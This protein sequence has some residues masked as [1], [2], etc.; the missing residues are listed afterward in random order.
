MH[1]AKSRRQAVTVTRRGRSWLTALRC[2][3]LLL[4]VRPQVARLQREME[5]LEEQRTR[6]REEAR[7]AEHARQQ[8]EQEIKVSGVTTQK[9]CCSAAV[10]AEPSMLCS[11][12]QLLF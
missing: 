10:S 3:W 7:K 6:A 2:Q 9:A 5:G 4:C 11:S 12:W 1:T 8:L